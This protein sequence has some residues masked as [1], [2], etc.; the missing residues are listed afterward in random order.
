LN[1]SNGDLTR[2][3]EEQT[4]TQRKRATV[5]ERTNQQGKKTVDVNTEILAQ[6]PRFEMH[7][8]GIMFGGM[9]LNRAM[10]NLTA[11]SKEWVGIGEIMADTMGVVMLPATLALLENAILPLSEALLSLPEDTQLIV[12]ITT[13]G[14]EGLGKIAEVGGQV[15]LGAAAFNIAFPAISEKIVSGLSSSLSKMVGK[16]LVIAVGLTIAWQSVEFLVEGISEGDF[17]K[18]LMG[19]IG[20][21]TGLGLAGLVFVGVSGGV[22]GFALGIGIGL[23]ITWFI[24]ENKK[25]DIAREISAATE[26]MEGSFFTET[27]LGKGAKGLASGAGAARGFLTSESQRRAIGSFISDPTSIFSGS[28]TSNNAGN[29]SIV[30]NIKV[31]D[32]REM[33]RMINTNNDKIIREVRRNATA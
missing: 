29:I 1:K 2:T 15:A 11:T 30:N 12:G 6:G 8:L 18:E 20:I 33:E 10:G 14:L 22:I 9:A 24:K 28:N 25:E 26:G 17:I 3:Y 16:G 19:I 7:F 21:G 13:L 5:T 4:A 32:S 27:T 23:I 31:S